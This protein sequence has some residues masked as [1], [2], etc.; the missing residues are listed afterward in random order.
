M[1]IKEKLE[2]YQ[3]L[4]HKDLLNSTLDL[5]V[6]ITSRWNQID[7]GTHILIETDDNGSIVDLPEF[8]YQM[9]TDP[10]LNYY[11]GGSIAKALITK[12]DCITIL[13]NRKLPAIVEV[14]KM[15]IPDE[16]KYIL[17]E[18]V[19]HVGDV[20]IIASDIY[21]K[22]QHIILNSYR[23]IPMSDYSMLCAKYIINGGRELMIGNMPKNIQ[24]VLHIDPGQIMI[25]CDQVENYGMM[26]V[27]KVTIDTGEYYVAS[28]D[29]IFS[30]KLLQILQSFDHKPD[31][32]Y[33]D[34]KSIY[35]AMLCLYS[36]SELSQAASQ[37]AIQY[38]K[39]VRNVNPE[40]NLLHVDIFTTQIHYILENGDT[41]PQLAN[42]LFKLLEK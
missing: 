21:L 25:K 34:F 31:I 20:D 5:T 13:D 1:N 24:N 40:N 28:P 26:K 4:L 6:F 23:K 15:K 35:A 32:L 10:H 16:S 39:E 30:Y 38:A 33:R 19:K 8:P 12:S 14:K 18:S 27:V 17:S 9:T 2:N 36:D 37:V 3:N 41:Y 22:R 29:M 7:F 42:F 11:F